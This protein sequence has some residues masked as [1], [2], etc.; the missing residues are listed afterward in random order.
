MEENPYEAPREGRGQGLARGRGPSGWATVFGWSL[1]VVAGCGL[2]LMVVALSD[3]PAGS[4]MFFMLV[5]VG[6]FAVFGMMGGGLL[7][8]VSGI[9]W[10]V[11]GR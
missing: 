11:S 4:V 2:V 3:P 7:A 10:M 6:L 8:V 9:G 1:R 5:G